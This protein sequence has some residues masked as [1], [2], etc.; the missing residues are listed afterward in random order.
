MLTRK[1][2]AEPWGR[3]YRND[4]YSSIVAYKT[5]SC[6]QVPLGNGQPDGQGRHQHLEHPGR[7]GNALQHAI[8]ALQL[9]LQTGK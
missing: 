5:R 3:V 1:R 2:G 6:A 4:V 7:R 8:G 9:F